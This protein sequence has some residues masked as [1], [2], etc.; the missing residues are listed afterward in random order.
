MS[1]LLSCAQIVLARLRLITTANGYETNAGQRVDTFWEDLS[2]AE[3]FPRLSLLQPERSY[4]VKA[5]INTPGLIR[6]RKGAELF[7]SCATAAEINEIDTIARLDAIERDVL[8]A[9]FRSDAGPAWAPTIQHMEWVGSMPMPRQA[10]GE[11]ATNDVVI[12]I[13]WEQDLV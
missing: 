7:I 8:R 11:H 9:C 5:L 4:T 10:G 3:D 1:S 2:D 12:R 6:L 13:T